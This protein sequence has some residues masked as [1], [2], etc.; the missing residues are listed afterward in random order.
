MTT[1]GVLTA[2]DSAEAEAKAAA[3]AEAV[4]EEEEDSTVADDR[5][6]KVVVVDADVDLAKKLR[7]LPGS[8]LIGVWVGLDSMEKFEANLKKQIE[9]GELVIPEGETEESVV[10]A[11]VKEIVQ[12]IEYG[13]VSGMFEF[14][15]LN[16][17]TDASVAQLREAA[18]FCFRG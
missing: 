15:I 18:E 3:A 8:R 14:T 4:A 6:G 11:K 13:V 16:D 10:R 5:F 1:Q 17:D 9:S 2:A 7:K 12:N